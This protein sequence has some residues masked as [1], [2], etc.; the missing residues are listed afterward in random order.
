MYVLL[1]YDNLF[2]TSQHTSDSHTASINTVGC[3]VA[4]FIIS[5]SV[6]F[7]HLTGQSAVNQP[8]VSR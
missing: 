7:R 2:M 6:P 1:Q 4:L 5:E 8:T 3:R